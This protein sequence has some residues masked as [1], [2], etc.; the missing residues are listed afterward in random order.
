MKN[1]LSIDPKKQNKQ[2]EHDVW[3]KQNW[4]TILWFFQE[5]SCCI[6]LI[7]K[8]RNVVTKD[9]IE[10]TEFM[11]KNLWLFQTEQ[12]Q[13]AKIAKWKTVKTACFY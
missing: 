6:F 7:R 8:Y 12:K 2:I 9:E 10:D 4:Q 11:K 5:I 1:D 3:E 13:Q